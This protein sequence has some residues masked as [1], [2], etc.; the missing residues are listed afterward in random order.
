MDQAGCVCGE[1][2]KRIDRSGER[3]VISRWKSR[4]AWEN[5]YM[6]QERENTQ[7]RIDEPLGVE[8]HYEI[9]DCDNLFGN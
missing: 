9:C 1:T 7:K 5:R 4:E 8:T 6:T 2:L 3:L